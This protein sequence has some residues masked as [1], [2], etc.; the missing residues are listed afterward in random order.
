MA[1]KLPVNVTEIL[2]KRVL[3]TQTDKQNCQIYKQ[4]SG[5][6]EYNCTYKEV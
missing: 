1:G 5:K 3:K 2:L 6:Y 4:V